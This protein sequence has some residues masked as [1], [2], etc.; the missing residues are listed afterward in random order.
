MWGSMQLYRSHAY[1]AGLAPAGRLQ[2]TDLKL[3]SNANHLKKTLSDGVRRKK[4]K[5]GKYLEAAL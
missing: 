4:K 5:K 1:E 2:W 3:L